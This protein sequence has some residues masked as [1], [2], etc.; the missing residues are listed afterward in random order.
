MNG[1][2]YKDCFLSNFPALS[3]KLEY[4]TATGKE[5][6]KKNWGFFERQLS[7]WENIDIQMKTFSCCKYG[8][9]LEKKKVLSIDNYTF[10]AA[11]I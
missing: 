3:P 5:N 6:F 2:A 7:L 1:K 9:F 4:C 8:V 11:I 10:V